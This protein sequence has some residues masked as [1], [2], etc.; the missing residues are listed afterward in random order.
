[1]LLITKELTGLTIDLKIYALKQLVRFNAKLYTSIV[2]KLQRLTL[3][4]L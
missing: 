4:Q 1:M 3:N 2:G